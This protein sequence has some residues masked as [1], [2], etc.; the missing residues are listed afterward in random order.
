M[1][2]AAANFRTWGM[3]GEKVNVVD[4]SMWRF[5]ADQPANFSPQILGTFR[6]FDLGTTAP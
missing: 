1:M 2:P 5:Q 3:T 4:L 6:P